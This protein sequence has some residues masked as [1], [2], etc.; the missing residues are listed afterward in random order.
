[1]CSHGSSTPSWPIVSEPST[2]PVKRPPRRP[3]RPNLRSRANPGRVAAAQALLAVDDEG[4]NI[5]EALAEFVPQD[6]ADRA[7][8]WN[9]ALGVLRNRAALDEAITQAAR[10]AVWTLDPPV[11]AALRAG[12][13]ELTF[14]RTP[15][16]AAVDQGV[17]LARALGAAHAAGF[18]NAILRRAVVP[19]E[20]DVSLG[21]P[22]WLVARWRARIGPDRADAFM[23]A[24]AEPAAVH[25]VVKEDAAGVAA[26]FQKA[27]I[28]LVPAGE[29]VFRLP[30]R[31][32][33]VDEL[34]GFAEGRWWIMDPA[35]VAVA[36]L[37]PDVAE[38]LDVCAAPGGK[39]LRLASR[40]MRV[41]ATDVDVE[42]LA[43]ITENCERIGLMIA[44]KVHDWSAASMP[45]TWP[46]VL[47]DAP[48]SALG[49]VR[50]H[51]EIRWRRSEADIAI[52]A[53][54][55][56]KILS[57]A[58]ACVAPGGALVYAVCSPEP[59]EGPMIAAKL[60]WPIE[61]TYS[62]EGNPEGADVFW[63]CRMRRPA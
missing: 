58:A 52:A 7:L 30:P 39:S 23:R 8:A 1:M 36:D 13:Y 5:E 60:G 17:E 28:V 47:V 18:V 45:G 3:A 48:C 10:R 12:L 22:R 42:R 15:P 46:A 20:G 54:R 40:G 55:Q 6:P 35:A 56:A 62:N 37:V 2:S 50:R 27:G 31:A 14:T 25:L 32:G 21:F 41:S 19:R 57:N 4:R 33:R 63:G 61:A 16:H 49:L 51:P 38:A 53:A 11:L 24:C 29:G 43:R 59:E 26:S 44:S 34:P 9:L